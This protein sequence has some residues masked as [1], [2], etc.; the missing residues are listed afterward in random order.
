MATPRLFVKGTVLGYKRTRTI[1]RPSSTLLQ[2]EGVNV[3]E[4]T[5]FYLGK[6][7]C[8]VYKVGRESRCIW[9]RITR[10]HG[11]SGVVRARFQH[12]L[13]PQSFGA[14]V[15]VHLFPSSI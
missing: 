6:R 1:Q 7:V 9:G 3:K 8:Y 13:P 4:D 5:G 10:A 15:R 2:L 12:N 14:T 11:N